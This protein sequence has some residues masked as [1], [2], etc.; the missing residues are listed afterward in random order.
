MT[1]LWNKS[2]NSM[3]N[4]HVSGHKSD[5]SEILSQ[6][7]SYRDAGEGAIQSVLDQYNC[8]AKIDTDLNPY[9]DLKLLAILC[10]TLL[11]K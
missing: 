1:G 2:Y 4:G 6:L 8:I 11:P 9:A 7:T 10:K 3:T 5:C